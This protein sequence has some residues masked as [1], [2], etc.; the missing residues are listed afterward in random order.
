MPWYGTGV[1]SGAVTF[2]QPTS[3]TASAGAHVGTVSAMTQ[4]R[5]TGIDFASGNCTVLPKY[6]ASFCGSP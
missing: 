5:L 3:P 1:P 6:G 4:P 2:R